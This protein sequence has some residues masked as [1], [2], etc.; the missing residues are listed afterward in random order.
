M[1]QS[2]SHIQVIA[3]PKRIWKYYEEQ[4]LVPVEKKFIYYHAL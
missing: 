2:N 1:E 3:Q 4:K